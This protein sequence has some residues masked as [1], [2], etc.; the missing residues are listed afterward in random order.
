MITVEIRGVDQVVVNL[1]G[2]PEKIMT[3]AGESITRQLYK[4]VRK[5]KQEKLSGQVLGN[6]TGRLRRSIAAASLLTD[7]SVEVGGIVGTNVKYAAVHEYGFSGTVTVRDHM[8]QI[9]KAFGRPLKSPHAIHV[10]AHGRR[11]NLPERSFLRS[12]LREMADEI[13]IT[14]NR[15][16]NKVLK[17]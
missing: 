5:V 11:V 8:R 3:A 6:P 1:K 7:R 17:S 9:K 15:D 12:A 2:L 16:I 4:L 13:T 10:S 14:L